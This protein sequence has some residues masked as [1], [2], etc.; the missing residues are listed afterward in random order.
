E[1]SRIRGAAMIASQ[2]SPS[3]PSSAPTWVPVLLDQISQSF[4]LAEPEEILDWA[5]ATFGGGLSVGTAFGVS[6]V[7]LM[8]MAIRLRPDVEIFDVDTELFLDET[9]DLIR[10]LEDHDGRSFTRYA[11]ELSLADQ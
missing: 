11:P 6:G 5:L 10:K 1:R 9:Y 7:V 8:D 4:E 2:T 3:A